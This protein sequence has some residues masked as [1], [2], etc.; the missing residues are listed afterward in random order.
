MLSQCSVPSRSSD[1]GSSFGCLSNSRPLP[2]TP[3]PVWPA[4]SLGPAEDRPSPPGY[5][6]RHLNMIMDFLFSVRGFI[7]SEVAQRSHL[8]QC[9]RKMLLLRVLFRE[10]S[11][12]GAS[13]CLEGQEWR[14]APVDT[15]RAEE[16]S[17]ILKE[18]ITLK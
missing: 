15:C 18:T 16:N 14:A 6:R 1:R 5:D 17:D 9:R 3:P 13:W 7:G 12:D 10:A 4:A 8:P 11:N 2:P